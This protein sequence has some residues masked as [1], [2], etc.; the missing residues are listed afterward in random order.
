MRDPLLYKKC[1][2]AYKACTLTYKVCLYVVLNSFL[3]W[4]YWTYAPIVL[5]QEEEGKRK[6]FS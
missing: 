3:V 1:T 6:G 4:L 5:A 2:L